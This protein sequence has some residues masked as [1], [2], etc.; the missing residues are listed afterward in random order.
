MA[1]EARAGLKSLSSLS[2]GRP[3]WVTAGFG[4]LGLGLRCSGWVARGDGVTG[5]GDWVRWV[6]ASSG[7]GNELRVVRV[8]SSLVGRSWG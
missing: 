6:L 1:L 4:V 7:V 8:A 2:R 5:L 3:A